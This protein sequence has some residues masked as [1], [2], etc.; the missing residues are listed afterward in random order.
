MERP[1]ARGGDAIDFQFLLSPIGATGADPDA[2]Y[3]YIRALDKEKDAIQDARL[4]Y[5]ASTRPR[6]A[7]HLL[8]DVRRDAT[9]QPANLSAPRREALLHPLWPVVERHFAEASAEA[10]NAPLPRRRVPRG[11]EIVRLAEGVA[12]APVPA[13][14]EWEAP[15]AQREVEDEVEFSWVGEAA[16]H[17][18]SVVH[19]WL[20]RIADDGM[21][22]WTRERVTALRPAVRHALVARGL[23]E[24]DVD[25][26]AARVIEAL[27]GSLED[28][29]GR[30]ILGPRRDARTEHRISA[31]VNGER[32]MLVIDRMFTDDD[33]RRW[34]VDYKTSRHEGAGL[35]TFLDRELERYTPQLKGYSEAFAGEDL[36]LGLY[37]PLMRG[38][39]EAPR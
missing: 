7:H 3:E 22:G 21:K 29:R 36:S 26:Y 30:W 20:Q 1:I 38:W 35:D 39:R 17:A 32:R 33:G 8:G 27:A 13:P 10:S 5:V 15:G 4:L 19:R 23:S 6:R 31:L 12:D 9:A 25:A 16:R 24:S 11:E 18:G 2:T 14:V 28:P 37:F 34:I